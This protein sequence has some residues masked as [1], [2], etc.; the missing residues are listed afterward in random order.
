MIHA[1]LPRTTSAP[2]TVVGIYPILN[3]SI[4]A[5]PRWMPAGLSA[6]VGMTSTDGSSLSITLYVYDTPVTARL[7]VMLDRVVAGTRVEVVLIGP[8]PGERARHEGVV[9]ARAVDAV[10]IEMRLHVPAPPR[11]TKRRRRR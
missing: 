3:G 7:D 9:V 11:V 4:Q 5:D 6:I 8:G 2:E 10:T 1:K